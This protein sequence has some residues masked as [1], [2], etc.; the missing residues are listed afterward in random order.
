MSND[1]L[2]SGAIVVPVGSRVTCSPPPMDTDE[3]F[4]LL[5]EDLDEAVKKLKEIGFDTGMTKEQEDEYVSFQRT[6]GGRF[7]SLRFGDVN[8]IVTQ[9]AFFFDRFLTATHICKTLNVM[10]KKQRILIFSGV[11]GDSHLD[12]TA[13]VTDTILHKVNDDIYSKTFEEGVEATPFEEH[14]AVGATYRNAAFGVR[15]D[16]EYAF[17]YVPLKTEGQVMKFDPVTATATLPNGATI[18]R[19][20]F[21]DSRW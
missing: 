20:A 18:T 4:L 1:A 11:F 9:S 2:P 3:D 7:K 6:S 17:G 14:V 21:E 5:V 8:Y 12:K 15:Q 16:L 13:G 19:E 10:D